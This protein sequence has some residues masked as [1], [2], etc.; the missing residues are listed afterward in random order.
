[1]LFIKKEA[2]IWDRHVNTNT[3]VFAAANATPLSTVDSLKIDHFGHFPI[4]NQNSQLKTQG[5]SLRAT[6][7]ISQHQELQ[8][9]RLPDFPTHNPSVLT[10]RNQ[11]PLPTPVN[12]EKLSIWLE[13]YNTAKT[14][15]LV[16]GF[17]NGFDVGHT[18]LLSH[19]HVKNLQ[20]AI[21]KPEIVSQ[22]IFKEIKAGR[23]L[24]PFAEPPFSDMQLS[25]IG[26]VPK[27]K[28][29]E[30]RL[31]H[32]LSYPQNYSI[33]DGISEE[34]VSVK[35]A[36]VENAIELI[37]KLSPASFMAKTDI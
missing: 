2:V 9:Q 19:L 12:P 37:K 11:S 20:S 25:P 28:A 26:L 4:L 22:K 17:R 8:E 14:K 7:P 21:S 5:P 18:G 32:H 34:N 16:D 27:R 15:Y 36:T 30:Y 6:M 35:Y 29:G 23:F 33:N 3:L 13:G 1:M 31:I 24:G 10:N